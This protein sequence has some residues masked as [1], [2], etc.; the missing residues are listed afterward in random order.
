MP[1]RRPIAQTRPTG[2]VV[3]SSVVKSV[4]AQRV[5]IYG[6]G[7]IGKTSLACSAPGPVAFFDLDDSLGVLQPDVDIRVVP[8]STWAE[9]ISALKSPG[10]DKIKTIV[11]DSATKAE[12]L[13]SAHV[14]K[15]IPHEKGHMVRRIE[16][17]GYGKGYTF[18]FD[19]FIELLQILDI[20]KA[21][22]RNIILICH[23]CTA[24]V[25]N[26]MGEDFPR[27]E[28]R[29]QSPPSG[30]SSIRLRVK[31]N[32]DHLLFVS[33][34]FDVK[35]KKAT[36][37]G[38]RTIYPSELPHFMAKSRLLADPIPF[39]RGDGEL[40]TMLSMEK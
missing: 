25:P 23:E 27:Y 37:H 35:N 6:P 16:D 28:P 12:E 14:V 22:G 38:T 1:V 11:I 20:H 7:G 32:V 39:P 36:G 40:W 24:M 29:L 8:I 17:Y 30:K 3:F 5:A 15:T 34:D 21:S 26:P 9:M 2:G 4:T 19:V 31:E 33:Y 10:W 13:A 18:I